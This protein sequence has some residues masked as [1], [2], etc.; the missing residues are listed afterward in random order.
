MQS[1]R[2]PRPH[3]GAAATA[4]FGVLAAL[5]CCLVLVPVAAAQPAGSTTSL[6]STDL[7]DARKR[8]R[9]VAVLPAVDHV[10]DEARLFEA[11]GGETDF[12]GDA[13]DAEMIAALRAR[14]FVEI[15]APADVRAALRARSDLA[16]RA[17]IAAE[18]YRLG[19]D[20]YLNLRA[21]KAI[22]S[23]RR[24]VQLYASMDQSLI[25]PRPVADA[26]F[27]LGVALA[28]HGDAVAAHAA[29]LQAF[30][31]QPGRRFRAGFFPASVEQA[32]RR[33]LRGHLADVAGR[34]PHG[35]PK[36]LARVARLLGVDAVVTTARVRTPAGVRLAVA[37]FRTAREG[38]EAEELLAVPER[39]RPAAL[40]AFASRWLACVPV[41]E[42]G[43]P[44]RPRWGRWWLDT[45]ATYATYLRRPTRRAFHGL[46][47]S[48]TVSQQFLPGLEWFFRTGM[49]TS[50]PDGYGDLL[51]SFN[52]VRLL[53][54]VGFA[55]KRGPVR[56]VLRPGVDVHV[57]GDFVATTNADC[58]LFGR[59]HP[60]CP[61]SAVAN[62]ER[63]VLIG[64][65]L[66]GAMQVVLGRRFYLAFDA[67]VSGYVLPLDGTD[68]LN[69]PISGGVG[70]GY[71]L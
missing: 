40:E 2:E 18:R 47:I 45:S 36:R 52:S 4:A 6:L 24:A 65:H 10:A 44:P 51:S 5:G 11:G 69:F 55:I 26:R 14:G 38:F 42:R 62:L 56:V 9:R 21:D 23:L 15:L 61:A 58:K 20:Y 33:G 29:L 48:A 34:R 41:R 32:L 57:L 27:M 25:D 43:D 19:L 66:G 17:Q 7:P 59:G 63:D 22:A 12:D 30:A 31:L 46:G 67:S 70:I 64:F 60:R 16:D 37:V 49:L 8:A 50:L 39:A 71:R 35:G 1:P 53:G 28:D 54:G 13:L 68:E 3:L